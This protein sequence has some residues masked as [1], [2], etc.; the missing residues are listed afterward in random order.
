VSGIVVSP[1]KNTDQ[2]VVA[3]SD[4][5]NDNLVLSGTKFATY[6]LDSMGSSALQNDPRLTGLGGPVTKN[7]NWT[8]IA[9]DIGTLYRCTD[10]GTHA[11]TIDTFANAPIAAGQTIVGTNESTATL[12]VVAPAGG[13]LIRLDGTAGTG[14]RTIGAASMFTLLK[15]DGANAWGISGTALS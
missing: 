8:F 11:W 2:L 12:T 10:T 4:E 14:T 9:T 6:D 3:L 7:A 1:V 5:G 15:L 13:S